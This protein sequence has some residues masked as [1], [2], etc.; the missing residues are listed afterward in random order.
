MP[1]AHP[2]P[3]GPLTSAMFQPLTS[4][5]R[6]TVRWRR[7]LRADRQAVNRSLRPQHAGNVGYGMNEYR[8]VK[9]LT[10]A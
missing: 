1:S 4:V 7:S 3:R 5:R 10:A 2:S 9:L 8:C 6:Y